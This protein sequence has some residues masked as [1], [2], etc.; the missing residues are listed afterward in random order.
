LPT[1]S[2]Y[3]PLDDS[4]DALELAGNP[5]VLTMDKGTSR[6][7]QGCSAHTCVVHVEPARSSNLTFAPASGAP[8]ASV[9]A[10]SI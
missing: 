9:I 5:N 3:T 2:W 4:D 1:G 10:P 7:G 6:F 8:P